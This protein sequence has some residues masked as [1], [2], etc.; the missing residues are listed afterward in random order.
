MSESKGQ[1]C[2]LLVDMDGVITN[3]DGAFMD[4]WLDKHPEVNQNPDTVV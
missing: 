3:W 2:H 1:V 4:R